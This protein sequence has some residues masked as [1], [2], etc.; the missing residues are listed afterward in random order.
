MALSSIVGPAAVNA[1][2]E[3]ACVESASACQQERCGTLRGVERR[4]CVKE[5]RGA[6][7]CG[8]GFGT[9]AYIVSSCRV[10]DGL[11]TG[12]Q[13]LR[14]RRNDCAPVTVARFEN[15]EPVGDPLG[16]CSIV[17]RYHNGDVSSFAGVFQRLGVVRDGSAVVFE[18]SNEFQVGIG[19]TPL[20]TDAQGLFYARADGTGLRRLGPPVRIPSYD[21]I[22][23]PRGNAAVVPRTRFAFSPDHRRIAFADL[24]PGP[25]GPETP[26][27]F[28][29]ELQTGERRQVTQLS[30][31]LPPRL[32]T[33]PITNVAFN[34]ADTIGIRHDVGNDFSYLFFRTDGT[35]IRSET[36]PDPGS[37]G[38]GR[39]VPQF[40]LAT[41][42]LSI[43]RWAVPGIPQNEGP[44]AAVE[45]VKEVFRRVGKHWIQL[46]NFGSSDTEVLA[47]RP[48]GIL[49]VTSTDPLGEN[50]LRNCQIFRVSSY[51]E[52]LRQLTHFGTVRSVKG[53][54]IGD[55][56]GCAIHF[57]S[58]EDLS[59]GHLF[60]SDCDPFV[61]NPGGSQVFAIDLDGSG[62]RQLTST[63]ATRT[64]PDGSFETEFVGPTARGG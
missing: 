16:L 47:P 43:S 54:I 2:C 60:Y 31:P 28:T 21:L 18:V 19:P 63:P 53:C 9:L 1:E 3:P 61:T 4:R 26:Q 49:V 25:D 30:H 6:A 50:P 10:R 58:Q 44:F 11:L 33:R 12:W 51:G 52:R 62:L 29:M 41:G 15:N 39:V 38:E 34:T 14:I 40:R 45:P 35:L 48:A 13:E 57:V 59:R 5:C 37:L 7:G 22:T 20:T 64:H 17:S 8:G 36:N 24:G 23:D 56:P 46:T 32:E 42:G 55:G 27:V